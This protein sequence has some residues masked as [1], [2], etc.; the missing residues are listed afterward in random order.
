LPDEWIIGETHQLR[1][2]SNLRKPPTVM[3]SFITR[4]QWIYTGI[5]PDLIT[6]VL[7]I[8]HGWLRINEP[9]QTTTACERIA[10]PVMQTD[11][12]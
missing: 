11:L 12:L 5:G 9:A 8:T 4:N 7:A 3:D 6:F 10:I 1:N 2:H